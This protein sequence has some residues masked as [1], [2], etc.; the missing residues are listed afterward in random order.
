MIVSMITITVTITVTSMVSTSA[1][2]TPIH[3]ILIPHVCPNPG[4]SPVCQWLLYH[5]PIINQVLP[6][7]A[8]GLLGLSYTPSDDPLI[9]MNL[10]MHVGYLC[11]CI[12]NQIII[13][14]LQQSL[15]T[16]A[17]NP[18]YFACYFQNTFQWQHNPANLVHWQLIH[19]L[20]ASK[21]NQLEQY[22][23]TKF[24]QLVTSSTGL[25]Y[26]PN[27]SIGQ[28]SFL[29]DSLRNSTTLPGLS[30]PSLH[31]SVERYAL[32]PLETSQQNWH[33]SSTH[34]LF[35][36]GLYTG[37]Q[38]STQIWPDFFHPGLQNIHQAQ[39]HLGWHHLYY[40][41]FTPIG[42]WSVNTNTKL[43]FQQSNNHMESC[44]GQFGIGT[45]TLLTTPSVTKHNYLPS[46][47][48]AMLSDTTRHY[49]GKTNSSCTSLGY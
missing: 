3:A 42:L 35:A 25:I 27:I 43:L 14:Q 6:S 11:V 41:K 44:H 10:Q 45:Y 38:A 30:T 48:Q 28:L 40:G 21:F 17:I 7:H 4:C 13:H 20:A 18:P 26:C 31:Y 5:F 22:T 32:S 19:L 47:L 33:S 39:Q 49:H 46:T 36:Y 34:N 2:L 15:Q 8:M 29:Q 24:I 23:I 12:S 1:M 9:Q 37:W 16:T